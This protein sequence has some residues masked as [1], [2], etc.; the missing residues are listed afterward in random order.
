MMQMYCKAQRPVVWIF[1]LSLSRCTCACESASELSQYQQAVFHH[2]VTEAHEIRAESTQNNHTELRDNPD[3]KHQRETGGHCSIYHPT[4]IHPEE[5]HG[6]EWCVAIVRP[7]WH[8]KNRMWWVSVP[9]VTGEPQWHQPGNLY[10]GTAFCACT[11]VFFLFFV[12]SLLHLEADNCAKKKKKKV[13]SNAALSM[14][15]AYEALNRLQASGYF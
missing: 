4:R 15:C 2:S 1:S 3:P 8:R 7:S 14:S 12:L 5:K 10:V 13:G 6:D 11:K 9:E